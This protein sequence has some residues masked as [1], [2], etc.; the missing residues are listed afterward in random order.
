MRRLS[1]GQIWLIAL[2]VGV[3]YVTVLVAYG[4]PVYA[5]LFIVALAILAIRLEGPRLRDRRRRTTEPPR[6][7]PPP[8]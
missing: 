1:H 5:A 3:V 7:Q 2:V 4:E 6:R 8:P